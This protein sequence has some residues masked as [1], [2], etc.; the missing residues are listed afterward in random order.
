VH[1]GLQDRD[2]EKQP[3]QSVGKRVA[4]REAIHSESGVWPERSCA[5]TLDEP[6]VSFGTGRRAPQL[7]R[8]MG[9]SCWF[10]SA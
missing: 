3:E 7:G 5:A 4:H 8:L 1:S 2:P 9:K 6:E 10:H